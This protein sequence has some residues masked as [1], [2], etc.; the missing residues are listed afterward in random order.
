MLPI[1]VFLPIGNADA[2]RYE[3][4]KQLYFQEDLVIRTEI[5]KELKTSGPRSR[6]RKV[7]YFEIIPDPKE[8]YMIK[9][10]Y[11]IT[12]GTALLDWNDLKNKCTKMAEN[13]WIDKEV[14]KQVNYLW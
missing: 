14:G 11:G 7:Y 12:A 13:D 9:N 2:I 5:E 3:M 4:V 6:S 8:A 10:E 1:R